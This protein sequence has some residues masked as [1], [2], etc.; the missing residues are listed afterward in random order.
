MKTKFKYDKSKEV[1]VFNR[2]IK[3]SEI[4]RVYFYREVDE[5]QTIDYP[6]ATANG[7]GKNELSWFGNFKIFRIE[8]KKTRLFGLLKSKWEIV[9]PL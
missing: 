1:I 5:R 7:E 4:I 8:V 3:R 2:P 6:I 9:E